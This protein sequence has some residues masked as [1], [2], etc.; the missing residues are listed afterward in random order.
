MKILFH[1]IAIC[2]AGG[3][4]KM[5][6]NVKYQGFLLYNGYELIKRRSDIYGYPEK[7]DS[8]YYDAYCCTGYNVFF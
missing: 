5:Q 4:G 7:M 6:A 3:S 2:I 1:F 8:I